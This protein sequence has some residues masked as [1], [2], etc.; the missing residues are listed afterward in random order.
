[1]ARSE[2]ADHVIDY[3]GVKAADLGQFDVVLDVVGTEMES[4][5]RLLA[6]GGRMVGIA[7]DPDHLFRTLIYLMA[8][9]VFGSRRVRAFSNNPDQALI[10][11]LTGY[12]ESGAIRPLV[13]KVWSL[14]ETA[15]AH[16]ALE[17]GGVR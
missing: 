11:E 13:E 17:I 7:F 15:E 5:R 1:M 4:Y 3:A 8:T 16:R 10:K 14:P 9:T 12:V 6:R 2:A